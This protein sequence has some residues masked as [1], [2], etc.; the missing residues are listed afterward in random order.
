MKYKPSRDIPKAVQLTKSLS[1]AKIR[2]WIME[3]RTEKDKETGLKRQK[4]ITPEAVIMW[5]KR[6]PDVFH[7]L[8]DELAGV[9]QGREDISEG[10]FQNHAFNQISSVA[11]WIKEMGSRGVKENN[12]R[13]RVNYLKRVC[14]GKAGNTTIEGW[15]LKHP[16][17]LSLENGMDYVYALRQTKQTTKSYRS[18]LRNFLTSKG[19]TVPSHKISGEADEDTGQYADLY[20]SLENCHKILDYLKARNIHAYRAALFSFKTGARLTATLTANASYLNHEEHKITIFEKAKSRKAKRRMTKVLSPDLWEEIP[21]QGKL[22]DITALELCQLMRSALQTILPDLNERI[23]M[24]FHFWRHMFAQ[25]MLRKTNWNHGVV[26][27]LGGWTTGAL[28][29]YY[30]KM[31]MGEAEKLGGKALEEL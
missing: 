27:A 11:L 22:F 9:D 2:Q 7:K 8:S 13:S 4:K 17:R 16:N 12:I 5:L 23:P 20:T 3:N 21:K 10:I 24:P 19:I 31:P 14:Q 6:N 18:M 26:A 28:E 25:H 30:G 15:G 29:R 1:P